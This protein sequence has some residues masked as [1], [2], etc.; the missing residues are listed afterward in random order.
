MALGNRQDYGVDYE[1]TCAPI[2]KITTI[3]TIIA[4][5]ASQ[6]WTLYQLDVKN[7]SPW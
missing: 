1:E 3:H 4:I 7:L 5:A 6:G 2:A